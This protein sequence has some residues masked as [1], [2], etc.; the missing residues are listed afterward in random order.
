MN[1]NTSFYRGDLKQ[2]NNGRLRRLK[3]TLERYK[4]EFYL[5]DIEEKLLEAIKEELKQRGEAET[6]RGVRRG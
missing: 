3:I 6:P 5:I 2:E 4:Q 1:W